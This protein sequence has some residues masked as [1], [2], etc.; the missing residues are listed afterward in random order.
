M[1]IKVTDFKRIIC[2]R[3]RTKNESLFFPREKVLENSEI[4]LLSLA[5]FFSLFSHLN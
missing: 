5:Y 3:S 2:F 1:V 4:D